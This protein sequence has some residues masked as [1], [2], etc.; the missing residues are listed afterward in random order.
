MEQGEQKSDIPRHKRDCQRSNLAIPSIIDLTIPLPNSITLIRN[1]YG[2]ST[3]FN[4]ITAPTTFSETVANPNFINCPPPH[5]PSPFLPRLV[6]SFAKPSIYH[7][8]SLHCLSY[9]PYPTMSPNTTPSTPPL[10]E[11]LNAETLLGKEG[12]GC[13]WMGVWRD[14]ELQVA[15]CPSICEVSVLRVNQQD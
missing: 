11:S 2:S 9:Y 6:C 3:G 10:L 14:R 1:P 8:I 15:I 13:F 7:F 12:E 5:F 4:P